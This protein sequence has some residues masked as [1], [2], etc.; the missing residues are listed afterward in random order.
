MCACVLDNKEM[1]TNVISENLSLEMS[2]G[3][4]CDIDRMITRKHAHCTDSN[5]ILSKVRMPFEHSTRKCIRTRN[6]GIDENC[7]LTQHLK[8]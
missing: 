4:Q 5:T 8:S 2:P 7:T 3:M 6:N 1:F